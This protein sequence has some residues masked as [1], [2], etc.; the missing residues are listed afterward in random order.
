MTAAEIFKQ[1][2]DERV[3]PPQYA[4]GTVKKW[5]S[6]YRSYFVVTT[7]DK[8]IRAR[9]LKNKNALIT[10]IKL[11]DL[12]MDN[13]KRFHRFIG[14]ESPISA[15]TIIEMFRTVMEYAKDKGYV[16]TIPV[17]FKVKELYAK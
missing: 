14:S 1:Y 4:P 3:Y 11:S 5:I 12:N 9:C 16:A 17:R 6:A 2:M 10:D 7:P 13:L 8:V 15:N